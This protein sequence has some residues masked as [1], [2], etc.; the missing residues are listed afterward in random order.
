M[1]FAPVKSLAEKTVS[2]INY[3]VLTGMSNVAIP[4]PYLF[5]TPQKCKCDVNIV[6]AVNTITCHS[7]IN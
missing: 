4:I 5:N 3:N 7:K 2:E 6:N 1:H